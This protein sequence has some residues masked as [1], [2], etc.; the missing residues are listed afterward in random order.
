M[1][2]PT[3]RQK[4]QNRV[5]EEKIEIGKIPDCFLRQVGKKYSP[6]ALSK[7]GNAFL[8]K[9]VSPVVKFSYRFPA[10]FRKI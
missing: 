6:R 2:K 5:S 7:I 3:C 8:K 1:Q 10:S 4:N 9:S